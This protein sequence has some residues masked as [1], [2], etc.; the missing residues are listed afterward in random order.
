M[1]VVQHQV[2]HIE[3]RLVGPRALTPAEESEVTGLLRRYFPWPFELTLTYLRE[4]DRAQG[5]KFEDY[6]SL[7]E[8][9]LPPS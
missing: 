8:R 3:M 7:V 6:I 1:Q 2:G 4:I 9:Q 5:M